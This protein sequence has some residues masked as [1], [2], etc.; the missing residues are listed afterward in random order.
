MSKDLK[1]AE[2]TELEALTKDNSLA[3]GL[4]ASDIMV[5]KILLMQAISG[6]VEDE[7]AKSGDFVHSLDEVVIGSKDKEPIEF[8]T[9]GM[10]KTIQTFE[11]DKYIKTEPVTAN[12]VNLPYEEVVNGVK[13]NRTKTMNYYVLRPVD[14]ENMS[15]FPLVITFK[16][17]S[18]KG[19]KKLATKL[20]M[21]EEFGAAPYAKTFNLM[22]KQEEGDKGKYY[23]MDIADGRKCNETEIAQAKK[24][25]DRLKTMN[26]QVHEAEDEQETTA[27]PS[28]GD[29]N[30]NF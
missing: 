21:L 27:K 8:I 29:A 19:G 2:S 16:R 25:A 24:W 11:D 13:V 22:A 6:L 18:L 12:N 10:F 1:K 28:E 7:K 15:V 3:S 20:L 5:P 23:V 30:I 9:L 17:T 4:D 26:V 14:I